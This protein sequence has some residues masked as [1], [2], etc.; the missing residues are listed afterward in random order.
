MHPPRMSALSCI[1][2]P[3]EQLVIKP[4]IIP[5]LPTFHGMEERI[6]TRI[7]RNLKKFVI[8]FKKEKPPLT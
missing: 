8:R 6:S 2:P 4:H 1:G 7:S 5:L 3:I